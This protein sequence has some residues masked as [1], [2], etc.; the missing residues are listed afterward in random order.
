M[1]IYLFVSKNNLLRHLLYCR[2]SDHY[3][4]TRTKIQMHCNLITAGTECLT[5][6]LVG[7]HEKVV[8]LTFY[9]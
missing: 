3:N 8:I 9:A 5:Y 1:Q 4:I 2:E 6:Y 7:L